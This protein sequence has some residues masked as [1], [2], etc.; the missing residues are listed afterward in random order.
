MADSDVARIRRQI[1]L[2]YE[3]SRR[4]FADFTTTAMHEFITKRQENIAVFSLI[5]LNT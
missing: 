3:A 5:L 4:V 2:E 1:A